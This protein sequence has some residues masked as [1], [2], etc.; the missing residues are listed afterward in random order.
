MLAA[1]IN[2]APYDAAE[3]SIKRDNLDAVLGAGADTILL[4]GSVPATTQCA[5][6]AFLQ[7]QS[8]NKVKTKNARW[9]FFS[10]II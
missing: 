6:L 7:L 4:Y 9:A 2:P 10:I 1:R 3:T 8:A 5:K